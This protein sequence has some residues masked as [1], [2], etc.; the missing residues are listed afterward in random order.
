MATQ[1]AYDQYLSGLQK[2]EQLPFFTPR[3]AIPRPLS[4]A[5]DILDS[6]NEDGLSLP[7]D[8]P[9][10]SVASFGAGSVSTAST[11]N[12]AT[13]PDSTG[14]TAFDF[15]IDEKSIK[16]PSGPHLFRSSSDSLEYNECTDVD[17]G[18]Q[19]R[20]H[21]ALKSYYQSASK[22]DPVRRDTPVPNRI[23][24]TPQPQVQ[25]QHNSFV[26]QELAPNEVEA[27]NWTPRDVV[28]WLQCN[29]FD[30]SIMETFYVNDISGSILLELQ[31][32]DLKELGIQ[33][34]GKRHRL[35]GFI[36]SLQSNAKS[37]DLSV[38]PRQN[39]A[40][41]GDVPPSP[42]TAATLNS[43]DYHSASTAD[44]EMSDKRSNQSRRRRHQ[45]DGS[46]C[47]GSDIGP[48]D[49]ISIVAIEQVLPR[50]HSCSKGQNCRKWQKQQA[51]LAHLAKDLPLGST[52]G[53]LILAGD[54]GN[55][56]TAPN[57]VRSPK[58]DITPS[59]VAS[60][61]VMGPVQAPEVRLSQEKLRE[62]QPRD[63]Q[64]NVRNFL[65]F[66][67]L[68]QLRSVNDPATPPRETLPS[69][70]SESPRNPTLS[71]N[72]RHLPKLM[73]PGTQDDSDA[74]L[75]P[76]AEHKKPYFDQ[77]CPTAIPRGQQS[78]A[79]GTTFS[80]GDFYRSDPH[81]G[82]GTP[83][84]EADVPITA[85]PIGPVPREDSQSV[86]PNM[87]FGADQ[88][89]KAEPI[90]RP[91]STKG[92]NRHRRNT[93]SQNVRKLAPLDERY[94]FN[95]IETPEDMEKTPRAA[96]C[97]NNPYSPTTR[98]SPSDITH[99]GWMK[100]RKTT[101]LLRHEWEE[102][103][104]TLQ[105]TQLAMH[106][107]EDSARRN[108]KALEYIDVDDYAVACSSLASSSKLTAAFKKTVLKRRNTPP[109]ESA[110]SFSLI[111]AP[112]HGNGTVDKRTL[113]L[114]SGKS[115]HFAV[116]TRDERIDWMRELML[117]K[118]LRRGRESGATMN[119]NGN[120][121]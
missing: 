118:A 119:V 54:P 66:Q 43:S 113:F 64:E 28:R 14:L 3:T 68:S 29:G 84:S 32:Q 46:P 95:P 117:A 53:R 77:D 34:F 21:S 55:P 1:L 97:R 81:Y 13:T 24:S 99:S 10:T 70:E 6:E 63:P 104:F 121:I 62:V 52:N 50:L 108:S 98:R 90:C 65:S 30:D 47:K 71:E 82:Q 87:R 93:S 103:H 100:K 94:A 120:L 48:G 60:S 20:P 18:L 58:S 112:P 2:G 49:S 19:E 33:S 31:A 73:I 88:H 7:E 115:H 59:L 42:L 109:D 102:H 27:R 114:N 9:F 96:H 107:D 83:F 39:S 111:P 105:G 106:E 37:I 67:N 35:M 26:K 4:E 110:F 22:L 78:Y 16:G 79:Y 116:K 15:H 85:I 80:P 40:P 23:A 45:K 12:E 75:T 74:A 92:E 56:K 76:S 17:V 41:T 11:P 69:P 25:L 61:D 44:E 38:R 91:A 101:R 89:I 72:L 57:L 8:S 36:Q 51:K 86:P 5:T